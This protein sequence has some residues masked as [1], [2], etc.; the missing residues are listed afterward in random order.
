MSA[1][2]HNSLSSSVRSGATSDGLHEVSVSAVLAGFAGA[3][4]C[5]YSRGVSSL[6]RYGHSG[7]LIPVSSRPYTLV[8][9][10]EERNF[11]G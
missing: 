6:H 1:V 3:V 4:S 11:S 2:A 8:L 5:G 9:S 7:L 10:S